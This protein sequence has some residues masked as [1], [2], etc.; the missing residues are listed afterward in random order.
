MEKRYIKDMSI[1]ELAEYF[2][3]IGEKRHRTR[4]VLKWLYQKGVKAFAE[5]TDL[6]LSLRERLD[7]EFLLDTLGVRGSVS[8]ETDGSQKFLLSTRDGS[9]IEAVLM[10]ARGHYTVCLSSQI[11]CPLGCLFCSTG[12]GGFERNLTSGEIL[13]QLLFFRVNHIPPRVRFNIVF[14]GMGDPLLNIGNVS[15][16]LEIINS[17]DA[18]ALGEKRITVSTAGFPER[19]AELAS[20]PLKFGLAVSMG[21]AT[22]QVRREL[23]PSAGSLAE[24]M[25]AAEAFALKRD[26]RVT[27]EYVLLAGVNDREGDASRLSRITAGRPFKINLIPFNE[28]EGC[29]YRRP[30]E[31]AMETFIRILLPKAPAVTVRRSQGGEISAACGQL[32]ASV[33]KRRDPRGR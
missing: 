15:T 8:S 3:L 22:E 14:M 12:A 26:T 2:A 31:R 9:C 10:E 27:L 16:A 24:T 11:G 30:S 25:K 1:G 6:P 21:G 7:D 5:M 4:Q 29:P 13:D 17:M 33:K 32:R 19:I 18:F 20:S 28:W 23:M